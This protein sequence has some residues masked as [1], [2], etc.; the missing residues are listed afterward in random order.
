MNKYPELYYKLFNNIA[1]SPKSYWLAKEDYNNNIVT[2]SELI[3]NAFREKLYGFFD[4][5]YAIMPDFGDCRNKDNK[6]KRDSWLSIHS[7]KVIFKHEI[8]EMIDGMYNSV[9][10]KPEFTNL[11]T[12]TLPSYNLEEHHKDLIASHNVPPLVFPDIK[13]LVDDKRENLYYFIPTSNIQASMD[14]FHKNN[15]FLFANML[16]LQA[17]AINYNINS[18][19]NVHFI[20][21]S[22]SGEHRLAQLLTVYSFDT[23]DV[24][25]DLCGKIFMTE[26][27]K[28]Q[29]PAE[30]W[31]HT[32]TKETYSF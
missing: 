15:M 23:L 11:T 25:F 24:L 1:I 4:Y 32:V 6:A 3:A 2:E 27:T 16:R 30:V 10:S 18:L 13:I 22:K 31:K 9:K 20:F 17:N 29:T 12:V 21:V 5:K 26:T 14:N 8:G 28:D 19:N 7:S